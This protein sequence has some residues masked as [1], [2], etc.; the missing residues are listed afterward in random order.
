[1][2]TLKNVQLTLGGQRLFDGLDWQLARGQRVGLVGPNGAGKST[3]LKLLAASIEPEKGEVEVP[4]NLSIGYLP[5]EVLLSADD[6]PWE[7]A[8]SVFSHLKAIQSQIQSLSEKLEQATGVQSVN[9]LEALE[10]LQV[11][12]ELEGGYQY[13]VDTAT[14]LSGLGIAVK[15]FHRPMSSFSGGWRARVYL[16][17]VLLAKPDVFLLDEPTNHLDIEA[18]EWLTNFLLDRDPTMIVVSHDRWF[19]NRICTHVAE[20]SEQGLYVVRGNFDQYVGGLDER[21]RQL[22]IAQKKHAAQVSKLSR[23]IERFGAKASK[24]KQAKSKMKKLEKLGDIRKSP[25][26]KTVHFQLPPAAPSDRV[27]LELKDVGFGY[28]SH[29]VLNG[30]NAVITKG[31]RIGIVGV[32][33]AGKSTLVNLICGHL[34]PTLGRIERS[35]RTRPFLFEQHQIDALDPSHTAVQSIEDSAATTVTQLQIRMRSELSV[36]VGMT[37]SRE[38]RS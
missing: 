6:T 35:D 38:L 22:D 31:T 19:L 8:T 30:A 5:Q 36:W 14:V 24:A 15:Q 13:E 4:S 27:L 1:M 3:L 29:Q 20:L 11:R 16:A 17:R 23:F 2:I 10:R 12:Y 21:A 37:F 25:S 33:G 18:L 32:N 7:I 9:L 34:E 26:E 28:G